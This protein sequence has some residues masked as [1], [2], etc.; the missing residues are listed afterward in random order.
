[1][2]DLSAPGGDHAAP[3]SYR[4]RQG[5]DAV[6]SPDPCLDLDQRDSYQLLACLA[7]VARHRGV[8]LPSR[9]HE[10][11]T[12]NATFEAATTASAAAAARALAE[13]A[14][15]FGLRL[16]PLS[17]LRSATLEKLGGALPV[18]LILRDGQSLVLSRIEEHHPPMLDAASAEAPRR[19]RFVLVDPNAGERTPLLLDGFA[20]DQAWSGEAVL[21]KREGQFR[22]EAGDGE[23]LFGFDW[24]VAQLLRD[25]SMV[26]DIVVAALAL[27]ALSLAPIVFVRLLI[28]KVIYHNSEN[29]FVVLCVFLFVCITFEAFVTYARRIMVLFLSARVDA[30]LSAFVFGKL[31]R[32]PLDYFEGTHAGTIARDVNEISRIRAFM[33]GQLL[34]SAVDMIGLVIFLPIMLIFSPILTVWTLSLCG[35]IVLGLVLAL[36]ALR[37]RSKD[38]FQAEGRRSAF[39]FETLRGIHTVKT[40]ALEERQRREWD[41]R[42]AASIRLRLREGSF[43]SL[44]QASVLPLERLMTFGAIAFGAWLALSSDDGV[45]V[46]ALVGFMMLAQRVTAPLIQLSYLLQQYDDARLAVGTVAR[47]VNQRTE[48]GH[49]GGLKTQV[50]GVIEFQEVR[51]GYRGTQVPALDNVSFAVPEGE[52]LGIVGRSGS[53]KTTITRLLQRLHTDYGG[54]IKI[55]GTELKEFDVAHLRASMGIVPQ[56]SFLFSGSIRDNIAIGEPGVP[57]ERVIEVARLAGA[58]E[59][60][61]QMPRGYDTPVQEGGTNLSGGQRQRLAI[62]RALIRNPRILVF[63]EATSALDAESEAILNANFRLIAAGRTVLVISHRLSSLAIADAILVLERGKVLD[64]GTHEELLERCEAYAHLWYKQN[65]RTRERAASPPARMINDASTFRASQRA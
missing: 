38:V 7:I 30:R 59:F 3:V 14:R 57:L 2:R 47:L 51:F 32:L 12:P 5:E 6:A 4:A 10:L 42:V 63:D 26:S 9:L 62:A 39:L 8:D 15:R 23:E 35:V 44:V 64:H 20:L 34:G 22:E 27:A 11:I 40:L 29:T 31:L 13:P 48:D 21:I 58:N 45:Y 37:R 1:M 46:G 41:N 36:P 49:G 55:G 65:P 60:I 28:D 53:G 17:R 25:R 19:F 24:L 50:K 54:L 16:Q 43:A 33:T 52:I 18:I 56:D 61:E